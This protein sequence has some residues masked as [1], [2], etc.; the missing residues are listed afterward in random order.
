MTQTSASGVTQ[1][2]KETTLTADYKLAEGFLMRGEWR[3]DFS[4]RPFFLTNTPGALKKDQNT[5]T[6]GLIWWF[7]KEGS[8]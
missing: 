8:W 6:L 5:A 1:V 7:G 2:L 3:R 4:N